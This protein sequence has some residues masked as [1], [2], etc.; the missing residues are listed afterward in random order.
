M[1]IRL[2]WKEWRSLAPIMA[3]LVISAAALH[4]FLLTYGGRDIRN[5]ILIPIAVSFAVVYALV[6]GAASFA[7]E[8]ESRTMGF[9][10]A[11]PVGRSM[12]WLGKASFALVSSILLGLLLRWGSLAGWKFEG[13]PFA[14]IFNVDLFFGLLLVEAAIWGLLWSSLTKNALTAGILGVLTTGASTIVR[15]LYFATRSS[16]QF[17]TLDASSLIL[18]GGLFGVVLLISW[19]ALE[20]EL[21]I[22]LRPNMNGPR[23]APSSLRSI[24]ANP[25]TLRESFRPG[26]AFFSV[27]WQ[28][29]REGRTT[30]L[31]TLG[32]GLIAPLLSFLAGGR[33]VDLISLMVL[34]SVALLI[35]GA[36][37]FGLENSAGTRHFLDNQAVPPGTVWVAKVA[38]WAVGLAGFF[39]IV[40]VMS[41]FSSPNGPFFTPFPDANLVLTFAVLA[42][43][44]N[45]FAVGMLGGMIFTRRITAAMISLMALVVVVTPQVALL[46]ARLIPLW[47]LLLSPLILVLV[48]RLWA[49]DWLANRSGPRPWL[50]LGAL[51]AVP[52]G[53]LMA[54]YV[55]NRAFGV[56]DVGPQFGSTIETTVNP[57]LTRRYQDVGAAIVNPNEPDRLGNLIGQNWSDAPPE[58]VECWKANLKVVELARQAA[59]RPGDFADIGPSSS[60]ITTVFQGSGRRSAVSITLN[61]L[62]TLLAMDSLERRSRG[63]FFG[64]W[65]D[66]LAQFQMSNHYATAARSMADYEAALALSQKAANRALDWSRDPKISLEA[67]RFART[68]LKDVATVPTAA[69]ALRGE[70]MKIETSLDHP[71]EEWVDYLSPFSEANPFQAWSRIFNAWAIAPI[72]ERERTRRIIR[73][74]S[75]F[76]VKNASLG[77]DRRIQSSSVEPFWPP[78]KVV[79]WN[80]PLA[81]RVLEPFNESEAAYDREVTNRTALE[82]FLALR[83]WQLTH[84]GNAPSFLQELVAH[85]PAESALL[86]ELPIDPYYLGAQMFRYVDTNATFKRVDANGTVLQFPSGGMAG[87]EMVF[88]TELANRSPQYLLYSVGPNNHDDLGRSDDLGYLLP[89]NPPPRPK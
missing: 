11:L 89:A 73:L 86:T 5:G 76:A 68:S 13:Q 44:P 27:A 25:L 33:G 19:V 46:S 6:A 35:Q 28:T 57:K 16:G 45:A 37:I 18:W 60:N 32:I 80:T 59:A 85:E 63:D 56:A 82:V 2:W 71:T 38:T 72:W 74:V 83:A 8:R 31:Q 50:K 79:F 12:L 29:V 34:C 55:A 81:G 24:L 4:W 70:S 62:S 78:S 9:L 3:T 52:F 58:V 30:W 1:L 7:G 23:T 88:P 51:I 26:P 54:I 15:G 49:G 48:S 75:V 42:A 84:D 67:I 20:L 41:F 39:L 66:I 17:S 40:V 87:E 64:A 69:D 43:L 22:Q 65:N 77:R 36:S 61:D 53:G 21:P 47:S 14:P 10:D